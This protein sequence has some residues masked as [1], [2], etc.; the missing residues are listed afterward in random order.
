VSRLQLIFHKLFREAVSPEE[1]LGELMQVL[2]PGLPRPAVKI[3][4]Q[5]RAGWL[6]QD[7]WKYGKRDG[8]D[9]CGDNTTIELQQ[10]IVSNEATLRRVLCHELC[11]H[12][13]A[14]LFDKPEFERVGFNT[15]SMLRKYRSEHG[16][17]WRHFAEMFNAKYGSG[18][19]TQKSDSTYVQD[20]SPVKEYFILIHPFGAKFGYQ[21][22]TRVTPKMQAW[23]SGRGD[24]YALAKI[25]D[26]TFL[27]GAT[28]ASGKWSMLRDDG[29]NQKLSQLWSST[30]KL[31]KAMA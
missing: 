3:V 17:N 25:S 11:H 29:A 19:V 9:V 10:R 20:D 1:L 18:F 24:D 27:S 26:P 6:G 21:V 5:L 13:E 4:N 7:S 16:E 8:Q 23:M 12:A 22:A 14:L 2:P 28:I 15:F 31:T 30:P